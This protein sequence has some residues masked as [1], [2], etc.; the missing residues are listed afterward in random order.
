MTIIKS[1]TSSVPLC[2]IS[3]ESLYVRLYSRTTTTSRKQTVLSSVDICFVY[4][5]LPAVWQCLNYTDKWNLCT[6]K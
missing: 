4:L 1:F 5:S 3:F 2:Q 6:D